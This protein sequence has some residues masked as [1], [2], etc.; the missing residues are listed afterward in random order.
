MY[1]ELKTI[2]GAS[3]YVVDLLEKYGAYLKKGYIS[4]PLYHHILVSLLANDD[5]CEKFDPYIELTPNLAKE[6]YSKLLEKRDSH[7]LNMKNTWFSLFYIL[8]L[9]RYGSQSDNQLRLI[10]STQDIYISVLHEDPINKLISNN[11]VY[12]EYKKASQIIARKIK[13]SESKISTSVFN[14]IKEMVESDDY[15]CE[16]YAFVE[17]YAKAPNVPDRFHNIIFYSNEMC[18]EN[19]RCCLIPYEFPNKC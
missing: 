6:I 18:D 4:R 12:E 15:Y 19:G 8:L 17:K 9:Y 2:P 16:I 3:W 13:I 10:K 1:D 11:D 5:Q 14:E 7:V